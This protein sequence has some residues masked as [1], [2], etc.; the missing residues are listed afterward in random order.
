M[1]P[2]SV[3]EEVVR[4]VRKDSAW[5]RKFQ[6]ELQESDSGRDSARDL[7]P[8]TVQPKDNGR[9]ELY[10]QDVLRSKMTMQT[11]VSHRMFS[12]V[13]NNF[14]SPDKGTGSVY[15]S[16]PWSTLLWHMKM[17]FCM[18]ENYSFWKNPS[19]SNT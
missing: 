6:Q 17:F 12:N 1:P 3:E 18:F 7:E 10:V 13:T 4:A 9:W 19:K 14:V 5:R 16:G 2:A 11:V 8:D 15:D